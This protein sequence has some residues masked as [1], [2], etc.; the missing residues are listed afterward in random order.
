MSNLPCGSTDIED[1]IIGAV[2]RELGEAF[3]CLGFVEE[4]MIPQP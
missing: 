1:F 4:S 2:L 3:Q